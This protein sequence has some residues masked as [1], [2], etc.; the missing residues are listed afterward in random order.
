M[1]ATRDYTVLKSVR[2]VCPRCFPRN[3]NFDPEYPTD[4]CDGHLVERD[5]V[6]LRRYCRRGHGEVWSL[7]E[8]RADLWRYL[9]QWRV[10]TKIVNPDTQDDLPGSDGL[11]IRP[12]PGAFAALVHLSA[13]RDDAVQSAVPG[14]LHQLEPGA[15]A[16]PAARRGRACGRD[17]DRARGRPARR[18]DALAAASRPCIRSSA[19][20]SSDLAEL[21]ITRILVNTN[22]IRLANEDALLEFLARLRDRVEIYL[23][24]DGQRRCDAERLRGLDLARRQGARGRAA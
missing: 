21:P 12:R 17:G 20:S 6:Y 4:I 18:R 24:Y 16:L 11:R 23:Q 15:F 3:E 9:Q 13:R 10:P 5:G 19:R 22:G 14:V 2:A 1:L 8:E 7:Y